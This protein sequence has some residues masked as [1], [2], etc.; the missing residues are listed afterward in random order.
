MPSLSVQQR[1]YR[2][3]LIM[4]DIGYMLVYVRTYGVGTDYA[5]TMKNA[6]C[7]KRPM[8]DIMLNLDTRHRCKQ[9]KNASGQSILDHNTVFDFPMHPPDTLVLIEAYVTLCIETG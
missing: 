8:A 6:I 9:Y 7:R 4:L 3:V 5:L 2:H 1:Q